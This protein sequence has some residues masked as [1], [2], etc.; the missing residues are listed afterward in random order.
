MASSVA[1]ACWASAPATPPIAVVG[2]PCQQTALA[3]ARVP[4]LRHGKCDQ[5]QRAALAGHGGQHLVHHRLVFE[6]IAALERGLHQRAPQ[7]G[8]GGRPDRGELGEHRRERLEP[9]AP[10]EE[11]VAHRQQDV[12]VC[13]EREACR[14]APRIGRCTSS[15]LCVKS[16][17]NWSRTSSA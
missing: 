5:R 6:A 14:A 7:R 16:S 4:Q 9:L 13:L 8:A 17:S 12:H 11:V 10:E 3:V 1:S 2:G 15:A